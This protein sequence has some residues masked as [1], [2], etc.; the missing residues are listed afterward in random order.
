MD[1][2]SLRD[3][4]CGLFLEGKDILHVACEIVSPG[5]KAG[6][7]VD[8]LNVDADLRAHFADA[9]FKK[10]AHAELMTYVG[11]SLVGDFRE[12]TTERDTTS[13]PWILESFVEISSAMPSLK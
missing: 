1:V 13:T 6:A 11:R 8:Q 3:L 4:E 2:K 7:G 9:A 12:V 10:V 5:L